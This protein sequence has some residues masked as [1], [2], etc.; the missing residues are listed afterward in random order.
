MKITEHDQVVLTVDLP[1]EGLES[2]DVG[3]IVHVHRGG[4]A[5]EV[6]FMTLA[7]ETLAVATVPSP[8]LRPVNKRDVSHVRQLASA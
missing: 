6:E 4:E 3:T 1:A 5:Y 2:G 7:G 8:R